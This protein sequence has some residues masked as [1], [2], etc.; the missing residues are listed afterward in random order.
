VRLSKDTEVEEETVAGQ[1]RKERIETEGP[2]DD[3][4]S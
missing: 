3:E 1:V 2:P 4:R